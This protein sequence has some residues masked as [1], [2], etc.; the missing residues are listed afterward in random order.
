MTIP[1]TKGQGLFDAVIGTST[2]ARPQVPIKAHRVKSYW[3]I[4]YGR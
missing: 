4:A 3:F 1:P 2:R